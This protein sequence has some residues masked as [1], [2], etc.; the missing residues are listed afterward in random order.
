M[1]VCVYLERDLESQESDHKFRPH[2]FFLIKIIIG[3]FSLLGDS[4]ENRGE[5]R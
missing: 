5:G 2:S 1:C 3:N 4:R